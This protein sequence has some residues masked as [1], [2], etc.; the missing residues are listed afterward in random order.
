VY[1]G[2]RLARKLTRADRAAL[3]LRAGSLPVSRL[4]PIRL[5]VTPG[6]CWVGTGACR[7]EVAWPVMVNV[8]SIGRCTT[9]PNRRLLA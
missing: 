1:P 7:G 6:T 3:A 2:P 8:L 5:I 4:P 9:D